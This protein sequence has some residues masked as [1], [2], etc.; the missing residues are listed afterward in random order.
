MT[1]TADDMRSALDVIEQPAWAVDAGHRVSQANPSAA[2]FMGY[3]RPRDLLGTDGRPAEL[4]LRGEPRGR[5]A[6]HP[7]PVH[8][9]G[10]LIHANGSLLP[11]EWSGFPL[12]RPGGAAAVYVFRPGA[13]TP[14]A[15]R[16]PEEEGPRRT[17]A[18]RLGAD[19]RRGAAGAL[20]RGAQERLTSLLLGLDSRVST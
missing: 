11:V 1:S 5:A 15:T 10:T 16:E 19:R 20:Q 4:P 18:A 2:A 3:E 14:A 12:T 9:C 6:L 8:G 13:G 17:L 7:A